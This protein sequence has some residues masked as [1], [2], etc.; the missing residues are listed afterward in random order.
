MQRRMSRF[1]GHVVEDADEVGQQFLIATVV[2]EATGKAEFACAVPSHFA[3]GYHHVPCAVTSAALF[4]VEAV[5][6]GAGVGEGGVD[7][8]VTIVLKEALEQ[9]QTKNYFVCN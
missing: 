9:L 7:V 8:T 4:G 3:D 1:V 6:A 2:L 5:S